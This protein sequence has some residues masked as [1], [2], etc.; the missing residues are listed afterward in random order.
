VHFFPCTAHL[1]AAAARGLSP[2]RSKARMIKIT[3]NFVGLM[4]SKVLSGKKEV[5]TLIG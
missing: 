5:K 3:R 4:T 2:G 1:V